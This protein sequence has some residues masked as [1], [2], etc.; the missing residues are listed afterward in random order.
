MA[1]GFDM[2][3]QKTIDKHIPQHLAP[4]LGDIQTKKTAISPLRM[5]TGLPISSSWQASAK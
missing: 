4:I 1:A 5:Q 2:N 3:E